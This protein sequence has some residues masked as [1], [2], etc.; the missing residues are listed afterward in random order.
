[1]NKPA[2]LHT[3][4]IRLRAPEPEDIDEMLFYENDKDLWE[5]SCATGPY[6]RYQLKKYIAENQ[7]NLFADGQLRFMIEHVSGKIAGIVD[8]FSFDARHQRAEIGIVIK[9]EFRRQGIARDALCLLERHCF[10]LLGIHQLYAYI[11]TDNAPCLHLFTKL[12]YT[13]SAT[14]KDWIYTGKGYKDI[15]IAQKIRN[16]RQLQDGY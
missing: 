9:K 10:Q 14:L 6:S 5:N 16:A 7:N 13:F 4:T 8:V 1:M 11:R 3:E 15:C 2:S 12:G